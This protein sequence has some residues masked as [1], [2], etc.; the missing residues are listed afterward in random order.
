MRLETGRMKRSALDVLNEFTK[1]NF[2][3]L[4]TVNDKIARISGIEV[5][6]TLDRRDLCGRVERNANDGLV[7]YYIE[8][9][10][11]K[12]FCSSLSYGYAEFKRDLTA[13]KTLFRSGI[14]KN[15]LYGTKGPVM[16]VKCLHVRQDVAKVVDLFGEKVA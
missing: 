16:S 7:D 8:E 15:L 1:R 13:E 3:K 4:M 5:A 9:K 10:E 14:H 6:E 2:G 12:A 11:I